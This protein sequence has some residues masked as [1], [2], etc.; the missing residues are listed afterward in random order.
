MPPS[1]LAIVFHVT[2]QYEKALPKFLEGLRLYPDTGLL[3]ANLMGAYA[4]L[5]SS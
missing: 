2:G 5:R 4:G 3:Y 1:N